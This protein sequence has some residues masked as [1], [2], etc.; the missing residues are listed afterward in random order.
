MG[1]R[2]NSTIGGRDAGCV[3]PHARQAP[4]HDR[5]LR[6]RSRAAAL[7]Q[8]FTPKERAGAEVRD[9]NRSMLLLFID[10]VLAQAVE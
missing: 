5:L 9:I 1:C 10:D 6:R 2:T 7:P 4:R 3:P 8:I